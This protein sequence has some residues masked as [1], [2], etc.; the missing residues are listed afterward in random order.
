MHQ[1]YLVNSRRILTDS[2]LQKLEIT[3]NNFHPH[4]V[5]HAFKA[6]HGIFNGDH[7]WFSTAPGSGEAE[8]KEQEVVSIGGH[9]VTGA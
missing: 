5:S 2:V 6:A 3:F 7:S 4:G 8:E 1:F 9:I